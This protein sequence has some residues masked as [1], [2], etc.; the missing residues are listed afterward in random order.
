M[1]LLPDLLFLRIE[2]PHYEDLK[3][4]MIAEYSQISTRKPRTEFKVIKGE[5]NKRYGEASFKADEEPERGDKGCHICGRNGHIWKS[6]D[7]YSDNFTLEQNKKYFKKHRASEDVKSPGGAKPSGGHTSGAGAAP[8]KKNGGAK[9]SKP[10]TATPQ[11]EAKPE[12]ARVAIEIDTSKIIEAGLAS[13]EFGLMCKCEGD[14]IDLLLDT[15][16]V[17]NLVPEDQRSVVQD[18]RNE[19]TALIGVG[20][21]RVTA[22]ETGQAGVFGKSRIVLEQSVFLRDSSETSFK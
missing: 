6:C 14:T 19:R 11:S 20:G 1:Q 21:A 22:T 13:E 15:G 8:G 10:T 17:S 4:R 18:I 12:Q 16:T 9:E 3:Q 5:D 7:F 2:T